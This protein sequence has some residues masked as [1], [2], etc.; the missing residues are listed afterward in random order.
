MLFGLWDIWDPCLG[1]WRWKK[2][3]MAANKNPFWEFFFVAAVDGSIKWSWDE[4]KWS[5]VWMSDLVSCLAT[6]EAVAVLMRQRVLPCDFGRIVHQLYGFTIYVQC[7]VILDALIRTHE[8][9]LCFILAIPSKQTGDKLFCN[10]SYPNKL[11]WTIKNL[12]SHFW[13]NQNHPTR[14]HV[15][16]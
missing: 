15:W 5:V 6:L 7:L 4:P 1:V 11:R 8:L 2:G 14:T 16:W 12:P 9:R 3:G 13:L 10:Q